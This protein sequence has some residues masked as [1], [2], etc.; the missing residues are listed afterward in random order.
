M[1]TADEI[2]YKK[3]IPTNLLKIYNSKVVTSDIAVKSIKSGDNVVV[4]PGCAIPHELVR[5]LSQKKRRT[6]QC[7][8]ISYSGCWSIALC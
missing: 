4:Q 5:A 1:T 6:D 7:N 8:N 2:A 3:A